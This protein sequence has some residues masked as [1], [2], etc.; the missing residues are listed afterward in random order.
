MFS[1]LLPT[2]V[3]VPAPVYGG[4]YSLGKSDRVVDRRNAIEAVND[5]ELYMSAVDSRPESE[6]AALVDHDILHVST[7]A[8]SRPY[9]TRR[10]ADPVDSPGTPPVGFS[11]DAS[12]DIVSRPCRCR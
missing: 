9:R 12:V 4:L 5:L 7:P 6:P 10:D 8:H 11:V 1:T 2:S 3:P